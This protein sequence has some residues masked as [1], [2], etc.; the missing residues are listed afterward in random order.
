MNQ[1]VVITGVGRGLGRALARRFAE[2]DWTVVGCTASSDSLKSVQS[3]LGPP[4]RLTQVDVAD[5]S[6]VAAWAARHLADGLVPDFLINN[7]ALMNRTA[8][9]W[10]V[11][12]DEFRRLMKVNIDGTYHVIRHWLP[13][14]IERG[15]GMVINF[16]STWGRSTS[17]QVAPYCASKFAIEGLTQAL[18]QE[19]PRGMAAVALN[20]GVINTDMLQIC[21]G[22]AASGYP[23]AEE[24]SQRAIEFLLGLDTGNNGQSVSVP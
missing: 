18:A 19:L 6:Q 17:P 23:D 9:L 2:R 8:V 10:E 12:P 22:S 1:T 21:F 4:H 15:S 14:M 20:P 3:E 5:D 13:A 24:W 7:A 11:P 16:S